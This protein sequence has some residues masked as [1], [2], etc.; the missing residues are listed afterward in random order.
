MSTKHKPSAI[1]FFFSHA[2]YS[3]DPKTET[4]VQG[5]WRCARELAA[6]EKKAREQNLV[7]VWEYEEDPDVS[8]MDA[9]QLAEYQSG[10]IE[11]L[12]CY[13]FQDTSESKYCSGSSCS[14]ARD[15]EHKHDKRPAILASLGN[16]SMHVDE[17]SYRRVVQAEL[18]CE[19]LA[20]LET[21]ESE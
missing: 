14:D 12:S 3:Y 16:I 9:E 21:E 4:R 7:F 10:A 8:W 17:R 19:A 6:A 15:Y 13:V 5:K 11:M 20:Q 18:A 2:G 1:R